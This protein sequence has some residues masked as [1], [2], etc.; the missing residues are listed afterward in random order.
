MDK[1]FFAGLNLAEAF[2]N[3]GVT[4]WLEMEIE[5]DAILDASTGLAI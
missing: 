4:P 2:N 5:T 1:R 3:M